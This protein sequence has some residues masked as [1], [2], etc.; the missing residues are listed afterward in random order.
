MYSF[1]NTNVFLLF[2]Q[3]LCTRAPPTQCSSSNR[4]LYYAAPLQDPSSPR[5]VVVSPGPRIRTALHPP[6]RTLGSA[7][8]EGLPVS[9]CHS[10]Y[11]WRERTAGPGAHTC[12]IL[13]H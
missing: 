10:S 13:S 6:N 11:S 3:G 1:S 4:L 2:P 12:S 5:A 8:L 9:P 7:P